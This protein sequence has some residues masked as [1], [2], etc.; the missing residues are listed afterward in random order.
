MAADDP[1][2][3]GEVCKKVGLSDNLYPE[4]REKVPGFPLGGVPNSAFD[5]GGEDYGPD[6][7][8][9][10]KELADS[11]LSVPPPPP[12]D[13]KQEPEGF[14]EDLPIKQILLYG[15]VAALIWVLIARA[16]KGS[17]Q[18]TAAAPALPENVTSLRVA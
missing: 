3:M 18:E 13:W 4:C 14:F 7:A 12:S 5:E 6:S 8:G 1:T 17:T 2:T 15:S 11:A 9:F 16:R 10:D